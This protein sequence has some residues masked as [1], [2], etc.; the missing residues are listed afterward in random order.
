MG[1]D[2]YSNKDLAKLGLDHMEHAILNILESYY[3]EYKNSQGVSPSDIAKELGIFRGTQHGKDHMK[4]N[5][6]I[7]TGCLLDLIN[8]NKVFKLEKIRGQYI[9][10]LLEAEKRGVR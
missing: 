8:H 2:N 3:K 10:S 7:I 5:D 4:M 1:G 6:A 9:L